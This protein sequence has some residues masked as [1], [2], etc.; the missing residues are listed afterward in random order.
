MRACPKLIKSQWLIISQLRCRSWTFILHSRKQTPAF[1]TRKIPSR[2][3][4]VPDLNYSSLL[5][6]HVY[7]ID[8]R[9]SA[10]VAGE[11]RLQREHSALLFLIP[12]LMHIS[13]NMHYRCSTGVLNAEHTWTHMNP[14][15]A[16]DLQESVSETCSCARA[17][18][19]LTAA[20][21]GVWWVQAEGA[22]LITVAGEASSDW[23]LSD[24]FTVPSASQETWIWLCGG[25]HWEC[26]FKARFRIP[27]W[28]CELCIPYGTCRLG[29]LE[30]C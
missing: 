7:V 23:H 26:Q 9:S 20:F 18:R 17:I 24:N 8:C 15:L 13:G 1:V 30:G 16:V 21:P 25:P 22:E 14:C 2:K 4:C 5:L 27:D 11:S 3:N 28:L 10:V 12:D 29:T 19:S 6:N